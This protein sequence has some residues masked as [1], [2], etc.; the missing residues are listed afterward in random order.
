MPT[1]ILELHSYGRVVQGPTTRYGVLDMNDRP[2]DAALGGLCSKIVS[3]VTKSTPTLVAVLLFAGWTSNVYAQQAQAPDT[4][5]PS[6]WEIVLR[7]RAFLIPESVVQGLPLQPTLGIWWRP[8]TRLQLGIDAQTVDNSGPGVQGNYSVSRTVPGAGSGNFLQEITYVSRLELLPLASAHRL[9]AELSW[10]RAVRSYFLIERATHDSISGNRRRDVPALVL[11]YSRS[12]GS[13]TLGLGGAVAW[14]ARDDAMY[15]RA[16]PGERRR[17]GPLS[18]LALAADARIFGPL[19]AWGRA[20][21]PIAGNNTIV[22]ASGRPARY[23]AYDIGLR[24]HLSPFTAGEVFVSNALGNNGA[25]AMVSDREYRALGAGLRVTPDARATE[26]NWHDKRNH[27]LQPAPLAMSSLSGVWLSAHQASLS[28]RAGTQ[29]LMA[30]AEW[31]PVPGVQGGVFLDLLDGTRDEGELGALLR[32]SLHEGNRGLTPRVG[33]VASGSRTNNPLVNLLAGSWREIDRL[34]LPKGGFRFGDENG[35]EGRLYVVTLSLPVE[36]NANDTRVRVAPTAGY[37]QRNGLQLS[38]IALG[39]ERDVVPSLSV[40]LDGG[41]AIGKGNVLLR[42]ERA[43]SLPF[44]FNVRWSPSWSSDPAR[45]PLSLEGFVT[46]K[47]G[48]SP[49]HALRVRAD[50]RVS[51]GLGLRLRSW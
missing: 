31:G 34:G 22:R 9:S 14:L 48:D 13:A 25:L 4:T 47:A 39:A 6:R 37:V 50:R 42:E 35:Y 21:I 38:G 16:L 12:L 27:H 26:V 17:F 1:C 8:V 41:V 24:L 7:N 18:G 2:S 10:S 43:H 51:A 15:L 40:A 28:V 30:S 3:S 33:I 19:D 44:S 5:S 20:L 36:W 23:P 29:G 49:F 11:T 46:N 32:V 45:S